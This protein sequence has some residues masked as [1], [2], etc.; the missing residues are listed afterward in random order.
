MS[1]FDI[2]EKNI[3]KNAKKK[4]KIGPFPVIKSSRGIEFFPLR[5]IGGFDEKTSR[6]FKE[7]GGG[8]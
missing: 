5:K 6:K 2:F 3:V 1:N 4:K 8:K 7:K